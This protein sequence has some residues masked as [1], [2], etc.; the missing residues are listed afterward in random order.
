MEENLKN[1]IIL[2]LAILTVIFFM[3]TIHSCGASKHLKT[4]LMELDK[5]KSA[6]WDSQQQMNELK[7]DK[8]A[9]EKELEGLKAE[10]EAGKKSLLQEQLVNQSLKDELEKVTKLKETLEGD[11][12]EALVQDKAKSEK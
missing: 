3:G 12:K 1:R 7:N 9:L 11:L 4:T 10:N 6:S 8:A 2:I 5:E